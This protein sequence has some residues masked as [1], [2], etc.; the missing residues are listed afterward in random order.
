MAD[1]ERKL[2]MLAERGTHVGPEEMIERVTATLAEEP[3]VVA[4]KQRKGRGMSVQTDDVAT[5]ERP[6]RSGWVWAVAAFVAVLAAGAILLVLNNQGAGEP[7]VPAPNTTI[8]TESTLAESETATTLEATPTTSAEERLAARMTVVEAM[9]VA[10][11]SGDYE[12][13][14][15][16]FPAESP[17][18]FDGL[19]TDESEL[20]WQRAHMAAND[21]WTITGECTDTLAYVSCP[22]TL[23][24]EFYG[25]AGIFFT[26]P[27]MHLSFNADEELVGIG[28]QVWE[29]AGDTAEYADA[30]DAWLAEAY[31]DVHASFGPRVEG[32]GA[33]PNPE[34]MPTAIQYVEEF[35]AQSDVYPVES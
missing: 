6:K 27:S 33:L 31:P 18:I 12:A 15:A 26:V 16:S 2:S 28:A 24:N 9:I 13:W 10:R 35:L 7:V 22:M 21:V 19:V 5:N 25:P 29:I 30:F 4:K 23:V 14:R 17:N 11:N 1:F 3:L 32:E 20:E 8:P 34:D